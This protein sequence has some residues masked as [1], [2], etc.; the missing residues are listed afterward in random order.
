MDECADYVHSKSSSVGIAGGSQSPAGGEQTWGPTF[1]GVDNGH[2][3]RRGAG[4]LCM[5]A[6]PSGR[7]WSEHGKAR[8][9]Q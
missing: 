9:V 2:G 5:L 7:V 4:Q 6:P 8:Q 3:E 1:S